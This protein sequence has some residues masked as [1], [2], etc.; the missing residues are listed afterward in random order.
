MHITDDRHRKHTSDGSTLASVELL[1]LDGA[2][3]TYSC[4][5]LISAQK[6]SAI[7]VLLINPAC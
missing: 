6:K 1:L 3:C 7:G 2:R 5:E 4:V